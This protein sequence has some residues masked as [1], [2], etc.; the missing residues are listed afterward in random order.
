[1]SRSHQM[2]RQGDVTKAVKGVEKAGVPVKRVEI[3]DGKIIV[4]AG[5]PD[6]DGHNDGSLGNEWDGV[7]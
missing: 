3:A 1:M 4:I 7:K 2:F 5:H 6:D